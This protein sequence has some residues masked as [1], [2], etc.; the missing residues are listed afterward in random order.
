MT[1]RRKFIQQVS[2]AAAGSI[3]LPTP[4]FGNIF[5]PKAK[6]VIIIGAGLAGLSAAYKLKQRNIDCIVLES[7]PRIGGRVFSHKMDSDLVVELGGE[8]VGNSHTRID[9]LCDELNLE[10]QNNQFDT[11]LI[12]KGE[13]SPAGKWD[14]SE[15]W[16][17]TMTKMLE[18]Y[19]N[20]TEK[21]KLIMDKMDWWRRI[22][23]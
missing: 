21:D 13:Y 11:H 9:E 19:G 12:Y 8:W 6:S 2:V 17:K 16:N 15:S 20:L 22:L 14:Y 5:T 3:L 1:T 18:D 23:R 10:L 4:S 7:R